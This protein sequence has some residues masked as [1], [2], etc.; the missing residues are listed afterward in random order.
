MPKG[1]SKS[2][3][4]K[5]KSLPEQGSTTAEVC[6]DSGIAVSSAGDTSSNGISPPSIDQMSS[7]QVKMIMDALAAQFT[8]AQEQEKESQIM[9][10]DTGN[11]ATV[12]PTSSEGL[13]RPKRNVRSVYARNNETTPVA[14]LSDEG[15]QGDH[16]PV[17]IIRMDNVPTARPAPVSAPTPGPSRFA[18]P[19]LEGDNGEVNVEGVQV[20]DNAITEAIQSILGVPAANPGTFLTN[21]LLGGTTLE[22]KVKEKIWSGAYLELGSLLPKNDFEPRMDFR[23]ATGS[24]SQFSLTPAKSKPVSNINEWVKL[25]NIYASVYVIRFPE[26]ASQMFTYVNRVYS[27]YKRQP[28]TFVWRFYDE[29]FR[30]IKTMFPPLTWHI[31]HHPLV[32]EAEEVNASFQNRNVARR[33]NNTTSSNNSNS[34]NAALPQR[35]NNDGTCHRYN[36]GSCNFKNCKY[37]HQCCNCK[38]RHPAVHCRR[39]SANS[40]ANTEASTSA[41]ERK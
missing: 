26:A 41:G 15:A 28:Q 1:A 12:E 35:L 3:P 30:R 9:D 16:V 10:T 33:N 13:S 19:P 22:L 27:L 29:I 7:A 17:K 23:Y 34:P 31:L 37:Q 32:Q 24:V 36:R 18:P 8:K 5:G 4:E 6:N 2:N 40:T 14:A 21:Y 20:N 25:F 39:M 38:G 11:G